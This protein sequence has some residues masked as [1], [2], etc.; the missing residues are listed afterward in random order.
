MSSK[1]EKENKKW[2][3]SFIQNKGR[4]IKILHIGNIA[5][6]A[7]LNA[8]M[9]NNNNIESDVLSSDYYHIMGCPEWENS[10]FVGDYG[11]DNLPNWSQVNL[12]GYE[13]EKWFI[14]GR[15]S[16]SIKYL[17]AK[18]KNEFFKTQ[19]YKFLLKNE[20]FLYQE[21]T[22]K[23]LLPLV[24]IY[25]KIVTPCFYL[26][27]NPGVI[28][29]KFYSLKK[30]KLFLFALIIIP[31][32]IFF[33]PF[34]L[35]LMIRKKF[36]KND[37]KS[38]TN[39]LHELNNLLERDYPNRI[40]YFNK[41]FYYQFYSDYEMLKEL[42]TFYDVIIGYGIDGFFPLLG[43][44]KYISFEHGTLRNLPFQNDDIGF[45]TLLSYKYAD[46]V[47]ITNADN[48]KAAK[49][50]KLN[51][52]MFIPHPINESPLKLLDSMDYDDLYEKYNTDFIVFHPSRQHWEKDI[53][54]PDWEKGNDVFIEGFA[55][56]VK[57]INPK[58]KSIFV[59]WGQKVCESKDL[60]RQLGIEKNIIW[61]KPLHNYAMIK[62]ILSSDL[63]ADQFYLGA[64]GSTTPK[65]L[66]CGKPAMLFIDESLHKWCFDEMPPVLNTATS[67]CV[68]TELIKLYT[69]KNFA[70][71]LS[72]DSKE[73]YMKYH[74]NNLIKD[75][76][77]MMINNVLKINN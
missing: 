44:K 51:N 39:R 25:R 55:K 73:W 18:N 57:E 69:D 47:I 23:M 6:N 21:K 61:I 15:K 53:R 30:R 16:S 7:Y 19:F 45:R 22:K 62:V 68:F 38:F 41:S 1:I 58:A 63:V 64:F 66:M 8:K 35:L 9:L 2:L 46:G 65:A 4:K 5:N 34:I 11:D 50:L 56:F 52:Y 27:K 74:S 76:L 70:K 77:L 49:K 59:E 14:Q 37:L 42:F 26:I 10:D 71:K 72:F 75:K 12:N 36:M 20:R 43:E 40:K 48:I 13:R 24:F 29:S 60:I 32:L 3:D 67:E 28:K 54:H 31:F 33:S 17:I